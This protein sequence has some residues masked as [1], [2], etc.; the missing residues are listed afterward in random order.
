MIKRP[1]RDAV[2][3]VREVGR[4]LPAR[5]DAPAHD[6]QGVI[7][8]WE[9]LAVLECLTDEWWDHSASDNLYVRK[10]HYAEKRMAGY[11]FWPEQGWDGLFQDLA[12]AVTE[13]GGEVRHGHAGRARDHREPRGQGRR[14][15]APAADPPERG[16]RGRDH[17]VRRRRLDAARLGRAQRRARVGAARLVRRPDPASS[18]SRTSRSTWLGLYLATD[19]PA[20]ILDRKELGTWL[21]APITRTP[22]FLFEQTA[23]DPSSAPAG[24]YLYVMGAVVPGAKGTD[25]PLPARDVREVRGGD[26]DHVPGAR[27]AGLAPAAPRP[28]PL[29]RRDPEAGPRRPA[30]ARTGARRTST[31]STSRARRSAAAG[32]ASTAPRARGSPS[33]RTSSASASPASRRPGA[34]E[35]Q[36]RRST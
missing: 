29:L 21:H 36:W 33:S 15:R 16:L 9:F 35:A 26:R 22:G 19:E 4:P 14:G 23:Y 5:V 20:A 13:N 27:E 31:A 6:D 7:D 32:S 24:K 30:T 28:Q 8:L 11:S 10:M 17:R 25:Q 18:P 3:G 12:D 2:R 34:T 1:P